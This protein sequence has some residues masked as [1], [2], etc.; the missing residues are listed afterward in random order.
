M[1]DDHRGE[2]LAA[3]R[4]DE[5]HDGLAARR[6][7]RARRLVR[8][9][10]LPLSDRRSGDRDPLALA[11][12][13]LV[14]EVV[15]SLGQAQLLEGRER[16]AAGTPGRLPVELQR[17]RHVLRCGEP[18]KKVVAKALIRTLGPS[19]PERFSEI[20]EEPERASFEADAPYQGDRLVSLLGQLPRFF[21]ASGRRV[22]LVFDDFDDLD[23]LP[24][25]WEKLLRSE[26]QHHGKAVSYLFSGSRRSTMQYAFTSIYRAFY[27][28]AVPVTL[29]PLAD[30]PLRTYVAERFSA[31][32]KTVLPL[33]LDALVELC[34]GHPRRSM[35]AAHF[36]WQVTDSVAGPEQWTH[37]RAALMEE[38]TGEMAAA[39]RV[40]N[41][42]ARGAL[43]AGRPCR[44][45]TSSVRWPP[46]SRSC[47][48]KSYPV[49]GLNPTLHI[50]TSGAGGTRRSG[51]GDPRDMCY[52]S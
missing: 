18:G 2:P 6:V 32:G 8:E 31:S 45:P 22:H 20:G 46:R 37:A 42:Y 26:I 24:G 28:Q 41:P 16:L 27:S 21:A 50:G 52:P 11:T 29:E 14:G 12:R 1:G 38:V 44:A 47:R 15:R 23:A 35:Q 3:G 7:E 30:G 4:D 33:A 34:H 9:Q 49:A 48:A 19:T 39:W 5:P 40:S 43:G 36:L 13:E 10:Q 51:I 25:K 17:K